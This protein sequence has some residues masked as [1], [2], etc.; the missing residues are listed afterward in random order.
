MHIRSHMNDR[1][2]ECY[3][4]K[5]R[6]LSISQLRVH[7]RK[8]VRHIFLSFHRCIEHSINSRYVC[9]FLSS[10]SCRL[11][12][13]EKNPINANTVVNVLHDH[14]IEIHMPVYI[15]NHY[16]NHTNAP[17]AVQRSLESVN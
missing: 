8:H 3:L 5:F 14:A 15:L 12:R 9:F 4:C 2:S 6:T 1:R 16:K 7:M 17:H 13:R 10:N 11:I